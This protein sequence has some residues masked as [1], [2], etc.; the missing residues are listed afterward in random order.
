MPRQL[1]LEI[2]ES[3]EFLEKSLRQAKSAKQGERLRL[4]WWL[5]TGQVSEHQE[6][7]RL[8]G[9]APST[10]TRWLNRYRTGGLSELL[11]EKKAPGKPAAITGDL[12]AKLKQR[13]DSPEG[14]SSYGEIQQWVETE[15]GV[16][17]PYK[18][19]HK[20]VRY[21]LGAK[22][23]VP[24]PRNIKQDEAAVNLFKKTSVRQ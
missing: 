15:S 21:R 17:I 2:Q 18:T 8:L 1:K 3:A 24:R 12:L 14:F 5:K 7:S 23:K 13:L 22:L 19:V 16:S 4:L 11:A 10:I 9:R 20:T 6:L